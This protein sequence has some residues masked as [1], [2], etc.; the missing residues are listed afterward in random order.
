[1]KYD[2]S[3]FPPPAKRERKKPQPAPI[4][5]PAEVMLRAIEILNNQQNARNKVKQLR[6]LFGVSVHRNKKQ[7]L[8]L[9]LPR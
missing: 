9:D 6:L 1:M 3:G 4:R 7:H 2:H 5:T 8:P